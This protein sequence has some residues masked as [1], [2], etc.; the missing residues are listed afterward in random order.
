M[1]YTANF[2]HY[3]YTYGSLLLRI[4]CTNPG[5]KL[6]NNFVIKLQHKIRNEVELES[7]YLKGTQTQDIDSI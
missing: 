2:L 3:I 1:T 4:N 6:A 7:P 5:L